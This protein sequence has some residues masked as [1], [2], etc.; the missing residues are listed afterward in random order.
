[1]SSEYRN[2]HYVPVWYQKRFLLPGSTSNELFYRDLKPGT[3]TDPRG[4]VHERLAVKRTGLRRCFAQQD[5][6]TTH[7]GGAESTDLERLFFGTVDSEGRAAV[8]YFSTYEH[9]SA[10]HDHFNNFIRYLTVQKLRTP[11]GLG[12]LAQEAQTKG[13]GRYVGINGA[14]ATVLRGALERVYLADR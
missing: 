8:E 7:F 12:W 3:F 14:V 2:N 13:D 6:Y 10:D 1:M 11:K 4:V 5:L 9:T